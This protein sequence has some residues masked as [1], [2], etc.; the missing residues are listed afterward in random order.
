M[1][2]LDGRV[3]IVTGAT[4]AM[5]EAIAHRL[6]ADGARVLGVGR[7]AERGR[8]VAARIV[9]A[10]HVADFVAADVSREDDVARAVAT[11]VERFGGVDIVV[12][13]AASLDGDTREA[14]AHLESAAVFDTILRVNLYGPFFFAKHAAPVMIAAG[15]GG[16]FLNIS[17]YAAARGVKGIPAYTASKGG[18]EALTRQL[19]A[20][21]AADGIRANALVLGSIA[22]P[23]NADLHGDPA[24]AEALRGA[25]M[26]DRAGTP[27][28]VA[29]AVAFLA[30]DDAGFITGAVLDIDG[31]LLAKAPVLGVAGRAT[32]NL[33]AT[34]PT[35]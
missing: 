7:N 13:N 23:R 15:R 20:E 34:A 12:N 30:C 27:D 25:R 26:T 18:L 14:A 9:A 10:G 5:G 22:V 8:A 32:R 24:M 28:D 3:A 21:Y 2:S 17:S 35:S 11:A 19:A 4:R 6:A 29:A 16:V 31:G 1:R 33:A